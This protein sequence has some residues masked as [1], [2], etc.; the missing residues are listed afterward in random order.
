[1]QKLLI[2]LFCPIIIFGQIS[3]GND[4]SFCFGDPAQVIA[5]LSGSAAGCSGSADS[6]ITQ[7]AGGNGSAGTTFNVINTSGS[8]LEITGISQGGTYVMTNELMEVWMYPGD[9]YAGPLPIG[10]PPYSGWTLVGSANINVLGTPSS[11]GHIPISGVIIPIGQT[12]TFRVLLM[13]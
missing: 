9:I 1:M 3:L 6:L 12:Y 8:S 10:A 11:L 7:V 5:S 13:S 2:L 4:Q